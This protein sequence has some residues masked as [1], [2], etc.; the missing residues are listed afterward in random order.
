MRAQAEQDEMTWVE[1]R[2]DRWCFGIL[3]EAVLVDFQ[4]ETIPH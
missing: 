1:L 3:F 4:G 2:R